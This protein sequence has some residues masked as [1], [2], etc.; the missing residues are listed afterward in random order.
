MNS[1]DY[2]VA[3]LDTAPTSVMAIHFP[4]DYGGDGAAGAR[5]AAEANGLTFEDVETV[6]GAD[7]QAGAISALVATNP[8]V[9]VICTRRRRR[10]AR[11]SARRRCRASPAR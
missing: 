6:P 10:P 5:I 4:G 9:V 2:A 1:V 7:N 11:S 3:N 8:G